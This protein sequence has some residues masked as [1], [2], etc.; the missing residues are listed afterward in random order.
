MTLK[1]KALTFFFLIFT[2]TSCS[3]KLTFTDIEKRINEDYTAFN[4]GNVE[5]ELKNTPKEYIKEYGANG[6]KEKF[7]RIYENRTNQPY[8]SDIGELRIQDRSKC[9]STYYYKVKYT[10]DKVQMTPY[11][12][13]IALKFNEN[14]HGKENVDF[15]SN[16]K[17]LQI[18]QKKE[19]LLV[20][21]KD[22]NWK[23]LNY[24]SNMQYLNRYFGKEFSECIQLKVKNSN[25]ITY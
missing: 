11:L 1:T 7:H 17:L 13:S 10:V 25:Y 9:N 6:L 15:N 19:K 3:P 16:S 14:E 18:R 8:F 20:Y 22:K 2:L 24:N 12:D 21:D 4:D 5:Y 23:L